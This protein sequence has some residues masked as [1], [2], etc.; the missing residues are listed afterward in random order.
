[1]EISKALVGAAAAVCV[2]AGAAGAYLA[3]RADTAPVAMAYDG[4]AGSGSALAGAVEQ[5]EAIVSD[6][7]TGA[8]TGRNGPEVGTAN[9]APSAA[10]S[11]PQPRARA[12]GQ[13]AERR[14]GAAESTSRARTP[15]RVQE[16]HPVAID[17]RTSMPPALEPAQ[18]V[19]RE[20]APPPDPPVPQFEELVIAADSVVGLQVETSVTSDRARVEDAVVAH[21]TRDVRVGNR[22]AI[23]AGS[24]A[25]GEVTLVEA[26][27]RLRD[28]ARLGIRFTSVVLAD[29]T[30]IPLETETI[31]R[32]GESPSGGSAAKIGGGAIGGAIIGGILG[33]A[34]GAA[35]GGSV[36]AGAGTAA[37]MTGGR[38]AATLPTGTHVTVRVIEPTTVTVDR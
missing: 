22:V 30:R 36:G 9:T 34:K 25:H 8:E 16:P 20:A 6:P 3:S 21:V 7:S 10:R 17:A 24:K 15:D 13:Q 28:R 31:Y 2:A 5:S 4:P 23:P 37:V 27:G 1:M 26:G 35:I 18:V 11:A 29:G 33:G 38:R 14:T 19:E 12:Q 32:E